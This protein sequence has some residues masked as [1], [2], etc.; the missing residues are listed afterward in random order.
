MSNSCVVTWDN[1]TGVY[2]HWYGSPQYI[3]AFLAYCNASNFRTPDTCCYGLARFTQVVSNFMGADGL[4]VGIAPIST[5]DTDSLDN[6]IYYCRGWYIDK[7]S[8]IIPTYTD[9]L[10]LMR[11]INNKM[12][13]EYHLKLKNGF[14]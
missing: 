11:Q 3:N 7:G 4:S 13:A 1:V 14:E 5:I 10:E 8:D 6:G 12:P 9:L 2:L